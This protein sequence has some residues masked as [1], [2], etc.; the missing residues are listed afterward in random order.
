MSENSSPKPTI[1]TTPKGVLTAFFAF[2]I[3]GFFPVY[4]KL[5]Q[6]Y[7]AVEIMGHRIVWTFVGIV[8]VIL[9]TRHWQWLS[10]LKANPKWLFFT[11]ISSLFIATNWW[12]YV[13]AVNN[14]HVLEASLGYFISPLAGV[15]LSLLVLK[16][17]LRPLQWLAVG[18]AF[19]GV[20]IQLILMGKIPIVS[21]A[22]AGTFSVYGLMH[23]HNPLDAL[24]A[25]FIE[26]CLLLPICLW[27]FSQANVA[28]S[29][30]SFWFSNDIWLLMLAGPVT[31]IPLLLF[32][33]STK[34]ISFSLLNFMNYLSPT[35]VFLLGIFVYHEPFA[36]NRLLTFVFIWAGLIVFSYDLIKNRKS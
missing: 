29:Q 16:E 20:L 31:L 19:I 3:W 9:I 1:T 7:G 14:N 28:S 27:W 8:L 11:F 23:R 18:F 13:W 10:I 15:L 30:L 34:M 32:N 24:S 12:V 4:F 6:A 22:L 26:T 5:L 2:L 17:K 35:L 21:L 25:M 36:F 33:K